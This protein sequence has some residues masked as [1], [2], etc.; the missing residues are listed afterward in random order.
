MSHVLNSARKKEPIEALLRSLLL[1]FMDNATAE[2]TFLR[3]FFIPG[4][5]LPVDDFNNPVLSPVSPD[6]RLLAEQQSPTG[7]DCGQPVR[8]GLPAD[9]THSEAQATTEAIWKQ[10]M[11]PVLGYCEVCLLAVHLMMW[12]HPKPDICTIGA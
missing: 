10:I 1:V 6:R 7:S 5:S 3:A 8:S 12:I 9:T 11:E 2:Y 4:A